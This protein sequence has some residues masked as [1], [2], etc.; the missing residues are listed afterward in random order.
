MSSIKRAEFE[1]TAE[2]TW[3][4]ERGLNLAIQNL[5]KGNDM[6]EAS[7]PKHGV[8]V[9]WAVFDVNIAAPV[10]DTILSG[11]PKPGEEIVVPVVPPAAPVP[12]PPTVDISVLDIEQAKGFI[13][14]AGSMAEIEVLLDSEARS[15]KFPGGRKAILKYIEI[16]GVQMARAIE[17]RQKKAEKAA[18]AKAAKEAKT[19]SKEA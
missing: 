18:K 15:E 8:F 7:I 17:D 4:I 6:G 2:S 10:P 16:R 12:A 14:T 5:N 9:K 1:V 3:G 13:D 19:A 11:E